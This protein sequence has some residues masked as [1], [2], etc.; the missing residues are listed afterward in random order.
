MSMGYPLLIAV[1]LLF[2]YRIATSRKKTDVALLLIF[3]AAGFALASYENADAGLMLLGVI[4]FN[5]LVST[6]GSRYNYAFLAMCAAYTYVLAGSPSLVAQAMLIGFLSRMHSFNGSG[7]LGSRSR[8]KRRDI[9]QIAIGAVLILALITLNYSNASVFLI[10]MLLLGVLISNFAISNK[11]SGIAA[12]LYGLERKGAALGQGAMWLALGALIGIAF[13]NGRGAVVVLSS[14][15]LGDAAATIVGIEYGRHA[16]PHNSGKSVIGSATYFAVALLASYP[17]IGFPALLTA[18]VAT[19][20]ESLPWRIDD[21]FSTAV[22]LTV[23][24]AALGYAA[25]I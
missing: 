13:L 6:L 7:A 8:E 22:A 21:N 25:I 16:L 12:V 20:I 2:F 9:V 24:L 14:I 1:A 15:F 11:G 3:M 10:S 18:S 4:V 17:F 5:E 23:V 19:L